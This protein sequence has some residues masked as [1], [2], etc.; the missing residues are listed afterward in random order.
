MRTMSLPAPR[1]APPSV[2]ARARLLRL[3]VLGLAVVAGACTSLEEKR[4][5]ELMPEKGFGTQARGVATVE[6][7]VMGGD[8]V[9]FLLNPIAQFQPGAE[10]LSLLSVVQ[11]VAIDGTIYV[12]YLGP[13]RV[14]GM[15]ESELGEMVTE[16]LQTIF[17][18]EID[19]DA[20]IINGRAKVIYGFG[21]AV[22]PIAFVEPD[23]T[24]FRAV[25]TLGYTNLA[26]LGRIRLVRPD[27]QNPLVVEV[28]FREMVLTGYTTW[29][30]PIREN[31][32]IYIP[33]TLFGALTRFVEKLL[34]PLAVVVRAAFGV[35]NLRY[36]YD[37]LTGD[38]VNFGNRRFFF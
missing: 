20:R 18:M 14:L 19:V 29:N 31:D 24:L 35:A 4:I 12:P 16:R 5:R 22:R 38:N 28:N 13:L 36:S 6:N 23:M 17:R 34:Q 11:P 37:V 10:M 1:N 2:P 3:A 32:I 9:Q 33:P 27:A 21:E 30:L 7:Y 25:V 8:A 15:T 26:N